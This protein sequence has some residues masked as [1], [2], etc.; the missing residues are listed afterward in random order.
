MSSGATDDAVR[1]LTRGLA[2][3]IV[4][5]LV[6]A[7]IMLY[8]LPHRTD[9]LFAWAIGPEMTAMMLGATY[10]GGAYFFSRVV[11]AT[12]WHRV[13]LGFLPVA[14]L[15]AILGIATALHWENFT[16]GH[17]SFVLWVI[18]YFGLPFVLPAAW[19]LNRRSAGSGPRTEALMPGLLRLT[20]AG[21]GVVFT[22]VGLLLLVAPDVMIPTWPWT[23][24]ALTARVMSAMF[25]LT[26]L[27]GM[28]IAADG[29][30]SASTYIL[31]AQLVAVTLILVGVVRSLGD[32]DWS[33][34]VSWLFVGGLGLVFALVLF[35]LLRVGRL[36]PSSRPATV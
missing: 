22:I 4:P 14:A 15:C 35:A 12:R 2:A 7:F 32:W 8:L 16:H 18:L 9:E 25:V 5:V 17:I 21:L 36:E 23:L 19:F 10:L 33:R 27:I 31:Q 26:G 3:I 6:A 11:L 13:Q 28:S 20:F 1:P 24:S 29:R 30:W 34:L